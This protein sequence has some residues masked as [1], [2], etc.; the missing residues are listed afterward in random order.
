MI[1]HSHIAGSFKTGIVTMADDPT[2]AAWDEVEHVGTSDFLARQ[3]P[4]RADI[5][6]TKHRNYAAVRI[7]QAVELRR[8]ASTLS[9]LTRPLPLYYSFLNLLRG[10]LA[11]GPEVISRSAHGLKYTP[12]AMLEASAV[13]SGGTFKEY[14]ESRGVNPSAGFRI[15]LRDCLEHI[16]EICSRMLDANCKTRVVPVTVEAF[17]SGSLNLHFHRD[18]VSADT[19]AET[20]EADFPSL[21]GACEIAVGGTILKRGA[22]SQQT[23]PAGVVEAFCREHLIPDFASP[24]EPLWFALRQPSTCLPR[25]G[26]YF[27]AMFIL[28]S[29]VRYDPG[30]LAEASRPGSEIGWLLR[31]FLQLAERFY[32]QFLISWLYGHDYYIHRS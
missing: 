31:Q 13:I 24:R 22:P 18:Y 27:V 9:L 32:P 30:Q 2:T 20:W 25:D 28:S 14:V 4:A 10:F 29:V 1:F 21:A 12:G 11:T 16:P 19:F 7:M 3:A 26:Y 8:S 23:D 15:S 5:D 17:R 6:W